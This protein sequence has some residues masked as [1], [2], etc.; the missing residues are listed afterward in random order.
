MRNS[1]TTI[2]SP[3]QK[4]R[5]LLFKCDGNA[6]KGVFFLYLGVTNLSRGVNT[7]LL[8][9]VTDEPRAGA[10]KRL[11]LSENA[12][13]RGLGPSKIAA[14]LSALALATGS[15]LS[16]FAK[17]GSASPTFFQETSI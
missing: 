7:G 9:N 15:A 4:K 8:P 12:A 5:T 2:T 17:R 1:I 3:S 6:Q 10:H 11:S 16:G 13:S 14:P